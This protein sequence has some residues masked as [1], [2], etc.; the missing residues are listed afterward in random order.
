[1]TMETAA[2]CCVPLFPGKRKATRVAVLSHDPVG[3][4]GPNGPGGEKAN[5]A[6]S[7]LRL[8]YDLGPVCC[9]SPES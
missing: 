3:P 5:C 2:S 9:P 4:T 8:A 6:G 7:A 1:M